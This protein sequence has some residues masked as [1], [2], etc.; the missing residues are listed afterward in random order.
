MGISASHT[1]YIVQQNPAA[2]V[3]QH[4]ALYS[5]ENTQSF[6]LQNQVVVGSN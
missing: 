4:H 2:G 6:S 3:K 1:H 5:K